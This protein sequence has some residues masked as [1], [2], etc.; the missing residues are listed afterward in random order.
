M[1]FL[2][3][4]DWHI[5][6]K[7]HGYNLLEDQLHAFNQII[8]LA[9]KEAVD[10][11]IIAGDLY[12]RSV[13]SVDAVEVFNQMIIELNL[14]EK[15]PVFA[16]S[17]NHDSS[18]RLE[19]GGPWFKQSDF[20]LHTRLEQA[21]QPI[22]VGDTQLFLLPYFE[23]IAARLYFENDEIRTIEKAM[24]FVTAEIKKNFKSGMAHVLV[25]HFFAAG[26]AKSDSE[27]KLT[28]GGL[29]TVP[30]DLLRDFDYIALGHLH[31]KDALISDQIRY[32]GSPLKFSLS[33]RKQEKGVWIIDISEQSCQLEFHRIQP[34]RE[35]K[36]LQG[37]FQELTKQE[38]YES[39]DR[40]DFM[41]IQLTDRS[42]IPNMMYQL[43][44]VYPNILGVE[45][46]YG[47]ENDQKG[48]TKDVNMKQLSPLEL[49]RQ[50]FEEMT[51]EELT[52][53]QEQW[54]NESLDSVQQK[55]RGK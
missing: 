52:S 11:I 55:E 16:I 4:A 30:L 48:L 42:V 25:S 49:S 38:F 33:E 46:V 43:R 17:G 10:G 22:E 14:E 26:S 50:F 40:K 8:Q 41:F 7:L 39:I 19:T 9:K 28:V 18:I 35:I 32:S 45:R 36:E 47:R 6:K 37:T 44:K 34:L 23:P 21:F 1:R 15:L 29:D 31:N 5:G 13:P 24:E 20:Y 2:H 12:D 3:T 51:E 53:Q 27:T 54:L